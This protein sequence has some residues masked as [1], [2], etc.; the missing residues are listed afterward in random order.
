MTEHPAFFDHAPTIRM[1][2]PLA[3]FLGCNADGIYE[4]GYLDVV[5]LAGHSC[6]TVAGTFL[7]LRAGLA[8]LYGEA[9]P[10][11]GAVR[12]LLP[13][14]A[15]SGVTGVMGNVAS[16][17]TGARAEDGFHGIGGRFR[18]DGLLRYQAR[19]EGAMAL[20]RADGGGGVDIDYHPEVVAPDPAMRP[21]LQRCVA[22][23]ADQ[24]EEREFGRL[25][26]DRVRRILEHHDDPSLIRVSARRA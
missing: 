6:P 11:R 19:T 2:D 21:L 20:E 26:Q 4:Y 12:V 13:D 17:I 5:K 3:V 9:V 15:D 23:L 10:E 18:R 24:D 7:M 8:A 14:S 1:R 16:L 22:G 25:W